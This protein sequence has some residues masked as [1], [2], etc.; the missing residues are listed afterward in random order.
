[1]AWENEA[2]WPE[3]WDSIYFSPIVVS[4]GH[5]IVYAGGYDVRK[6]YSYNITTDTWTELA[7]PPVS[8][9]N[10]IAMSPNGTKLVASGLWDKSLRIYDIAGNSW[11]SSLAPYTVPGGVKLYLL[12]FVWADDDTVWCEVQGYD[13]G[14]WY[15]KIFRYVVSTNTWTQFPN[16]E[17]QTYGNG[18]C[19][20]INTAGTILYVVPEGAVM[21]R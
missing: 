5:H 14:S 15:I 2:N 11:S 10:P 3:A 13:G 9:Y 21:I 16:F 7:A 18:T 20:S 12:T 19:M 17:L 6:F 8:I 1:M 4:G